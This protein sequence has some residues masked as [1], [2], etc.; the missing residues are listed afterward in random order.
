MNTTCDN[1]KF[2]MA[3]NDETDCTNW[4]VKGTYPIPCPKEYTCDR[5]MMEEAPIISNPA[6]HTVT[7]FEKVKSLTEL[8][9]SIFACHKSGKIFKPFTS[10][11]IGFARWLEQPLDT[12]FWERFEN[13]MDNL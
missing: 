9:Y 3:I 13:Y 6:E 7:N 11:V 4:C 10:S 1:C 5:W 2:R 8:E 12:E